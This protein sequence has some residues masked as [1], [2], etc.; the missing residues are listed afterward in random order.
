MDVSER[1]AVEKA[2]RSDSRRGSHGDSGRLAA[3]DV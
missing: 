2:A 3:E 1:A